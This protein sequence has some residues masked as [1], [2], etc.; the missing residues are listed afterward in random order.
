[1]YRRLLFY[2]WLR[3]RSFH[4]TSLRD[5]LE[6]IGF[7]RTLMWQALIKLLP[8]LNS[9]P[10]MLWMLFKWIISRIIRGRR[11][12]RLS[13]RVKCRDI[14][15]TFCIKVYLRN[16]TKLTYGIPDCRQQNLPDSL[17]VLKLDLCLCWM[18]IHIDIRWCHFK[19]DKVWDL[20]ANRYQTFK[21]LHDCLME[22]SMFH[23]TPI[24]KETILRT[25]FPRRLRFSHK[26]SN[27]T[28][29][30]F[31]IYRQQVLI[32]TFPKNISNTLTKRTTPQVHQFLSIT[33]K[34]EVDLWIDKDNPFKGSQDVIQL[35]RIRLQELTSC[36]NIEKKILH[37]KTTTDRTIDWFLRLHL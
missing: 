4:V 18:N 8:S 36:R 35:R 30:R 32:E 25:F 22:I 34:R 2:E 15:T 14:R 27:L 26:T 20:H 5:W 6:D 7:D 33:M 3:I 1:M 13:L 12:I 11:H 9:F 10:W 17:F 19:I 23:K 21:S 24:D 16:L 37:F 29:G 28:H 31:H